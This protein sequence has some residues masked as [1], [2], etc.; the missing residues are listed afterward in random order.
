MPSRPLFLVVLVTLAVAIG[1]LVGSAAGVRV[2]EA[3][4]SAGYTAGPWRCK[5]FDGEDGI[6]QR[7]A[8]W[9]YRYAY[10]GPGQVVSLS[11]AASGSRTST[12]LCAWNPGFAANQWI[13]SEKDRR[14]HEARVRARKRTLQQHKQKGGDELFPEDVPLEEDDSRGDR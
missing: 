3:E 5:A 12:T 11:T 6:E 7:A 4:G 2:A 14:D 1:V 10:T 9:L 8:A 13:Q